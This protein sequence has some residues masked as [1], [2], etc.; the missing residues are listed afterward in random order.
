MDKSSSGSMQKGKRGR[1]ASAKVV[2]PGM[3]KCQKVY[4]LA[5]GHRKSSKMML[6]LDCISCSP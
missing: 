2:V 3:L 1:D 4:T 6:N 5:V